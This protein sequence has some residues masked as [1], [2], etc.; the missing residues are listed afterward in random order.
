MHLGKDG[1]QESKQPRPSV[2]QMTEDLLTDL[3]LMD[4]ADKQ[5]VALTS[6]AKRK[7]S[8]AIALIGDPQVWLPLSKWRG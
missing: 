6:P 1:L 3:Q 7:L 2:E 5:A 8:L 4:D